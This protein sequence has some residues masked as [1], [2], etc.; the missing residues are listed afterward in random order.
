[1]NMYNEDTVILISKIIDFFLFIFQIKQM[2]KCK[3]DSIR[4][5]ILSIQ[6]PER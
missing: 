6:V 3:C 1:M 2:D 4:T 5:K